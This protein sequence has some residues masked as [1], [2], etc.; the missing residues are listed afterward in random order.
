MGAKIREKPKGSGVW[1]VFISHNGRRKSKRIGKDKRL[2]REVAKKVEARL[3][4]GDLSID[5]ARTFKQYSKT[6]IDIVVPATCKEQTA[7]DYKALLKNHVL[8]EFGDIRVNEINKLMLKSFLMK[9]YKSGVA[10]S[11][12]NHVKSVISGVLNL[13]VDDGTIPANTCHRLGKLYRE[14]QISEEINPLSRDELSLLLNSFKE[15]YPNDYPLALLLART[16]VRLGEAFALQW[17]DIDFNERFITVQRNIVNGK[18]TT[19]KND[20]SRR[21]DMSK[22]LTQALLDLRHQRKSETIK[23]G[24]G[25]VPEWVFINAKGNPL[26]K[27]HWRKRV[28]YKA[29]EKAKLRKIRIHDLRH[30]YASLLIQANESLAYIRDQLGH[31]SIKVTVDIYGHL[32]PGGNKEAVDRLDD[33]EYFDAPKRTLSAPKKKNGVRNVA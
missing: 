5:D 14:K 28:F 2:A 25:Q 27:N 12:V 26:D 4:R 6:W 19:P 33:S 13:A 24:W 31:H 7:E 3:I 29:L 10:A 32:A 30:T 16:G 22:Q 9:K 17:G 23:K 11:T 1:W 21:V 18:I 15:H 20:K 8:T